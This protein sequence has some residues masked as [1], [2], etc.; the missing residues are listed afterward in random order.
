[1][2]FSLSQ[3]T[4]DVQNV[5]ENAAPG[6]AGAIVGQAVFQQLGS[7]DH[8]IKLGGTPVLSLSSPRGN[9][10][11]LPLLLAAAIVIVLVIAD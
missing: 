10:L 7:G 9:D 6:V 1:M 11:T 5:A 4:E 3:F 2:S 8:D